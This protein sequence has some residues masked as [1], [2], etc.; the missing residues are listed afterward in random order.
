VLE[1]IVDGLIASLKVTSIFVF[2]G[3][4]VAPLAGNTEVTVG[5]MVSEDEIITEALRPADTL[6]AASLAQAYSV[7]VPVLVNT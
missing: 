6:P 1:L 4:L 7:F 5:L 2:L 3:M